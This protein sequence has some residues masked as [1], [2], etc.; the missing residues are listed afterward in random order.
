[1]T[2]HP[3]Q[4]A[5]AQGRGTLAVINNKNYTQYMIKQNIGFITIS[6]IIILTTS[7]LTSQHNQHVYLTNDKYDSTSNSTSFSYLGDNSINAQIPGKWKYIGF[8]KDS[9]DHTF[10]DS[11][12][13][14]L[15]IFKGTR[16]TSSFNKN[17]LDGD[18][19]IDLFYKWD[20]EWYLTNN[21]LVAEYVDSTYETT[22]LYGTLNGN[23][24]RISIQSKLNKN[25]QTELVSTIYINLR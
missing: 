6:I 10:R 23:G 5:T 4:T 11:L 15:L 16:G 20:S 24:V 12:N 18:D 3:T 14:I 22:S 21:S 19:F 7:C 13:Q 25:I 1:L 2:N 9:R 17:N 8:N